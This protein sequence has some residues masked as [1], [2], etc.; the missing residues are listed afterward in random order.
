MA[1]NFSTPLADAGRLGAG[2]RCGAA[3]FEHR[4]CARADR[5][6]GRRRCGGAGAVLAAPIVDTVKRERDGVVSETV[7][8][9]GLWR[10]LTP[11]VFA[12]AQLRDALSSDASARRRR[13]R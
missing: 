11:Q 1:S 6:A 3:L 13:D 8:R 2:A 12:F 5:R 10:A 7:D 4:R 9:T